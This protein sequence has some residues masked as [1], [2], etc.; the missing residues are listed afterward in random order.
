MNS[1]NAILNFLQSWPCASMIS[2]PSTMTIRAPVGSCKECREEALSSPGQ[3]SSCSSKFVRDVSPG[4]H[5]E[6]R[7]SMS[8]Q[9]RR[10][11]AKWT[12]RRNSCGG[13]VTEQPT[14]TM[15]KQAMPIFFRCVFFGDVHC[16][17][18]DGSVDSPLCSKK[19]A[20]DQPANCLRRSVDPL[21]GQRMA[22]MF[23]GGNAPQESGKHSASKSL[24]RNTD[25]DL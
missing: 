7:V 15:Y 24:G 20:R 1:D 17:V 11:V 14:D 9:T 10:L 5:R 8:Q 18:E 25:D 19:T 22:Q 3:P 4:A 6:T 12:R 2:I 23:W 13:E 21:M 16:P